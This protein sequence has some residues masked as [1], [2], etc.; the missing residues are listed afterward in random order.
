MSDASVHLQMYICLRQDQIVTN[1]FRQKDINPLNQHI[2]WI[3]F[4]VKTL[5][6]VQL[7][8]ANQIIFRQTRTNTFWLN[9]QKQLLD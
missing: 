9:K 8:I 1:D 5:S 2:D 6:A 7:K 3:N 4:V